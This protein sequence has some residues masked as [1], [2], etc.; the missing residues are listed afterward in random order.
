MDD[1]PQTRTEIITALFDAHADSV[2]RYARYSLPPDIDARDVVQEVFLRAFRAWNNFHGDADPKTWLLRIARNY[3]YDLLRAKRRQREFEAMRSLDDATSTNLNS[4]LEL[5][6]AV[7]RLSPDYQQV[8]NL[9]W[10]E[11]L[12]VTQTA[13]ILDWTEAKVRLTFHRAKKKLKELLD[14]P[15]TAVDP[16]NLS[17][18]PA[19][20]TQGG[21]GRHDKRGQ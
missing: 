8:L 4:I 7:S 11:D 17:I 6:D 19:E 14:Q 15:L 10:I 21:D 13:E 3:V 2:Y 1:P 12:S 5:E 9:R 20:S 16:P 18:L